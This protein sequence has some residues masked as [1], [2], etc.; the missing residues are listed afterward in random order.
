LYILEE[1]LKQRLSPVENY[2]SGVILP[3][4]TCSLTGTREDVISR[5]YAPFWAFERGKPINDIP[6]RDVLSRMSSSD[7]FIKGANAIDPKRR[8]GVLLGLWTGGTIG[9]ALPIILARGI[10]LIIPVGLE[11]MI[12]TSIEIAAKESGIQRTDYSRGLPVGLMPLPGTVITEVEAI[13]ILTGAK[14]I[15]IAAGGISGAEGSVLLVIKGTDDQVKQAIK[16]IETI[17][18]ERGPQIPL[19]NCLQCKILTCYYAKVKG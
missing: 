13:A 7:V 6:L 18:G 17:S 4:R 15:P 5:G 8:A 19:P 9:V 2:L 10:N 3:G 16:I 14:A 1:L 12:P 11:K